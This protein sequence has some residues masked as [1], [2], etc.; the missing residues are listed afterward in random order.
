MT[1]PLIGLVAFVV[2]ALVGWAIAEAKSKA[3][4]FEH[5]EEEREEAELIYR[6]REEEG[7]REKGLKD[8][9]QSNST[10]GFKAV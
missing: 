4:T 8:I 2:I 6:E 9:L 10:K 7:F 3:V 5:S 1:T